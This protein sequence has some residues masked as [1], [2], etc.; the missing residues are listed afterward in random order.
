VFCHVIR[1]FEPEI[2]KVR[3]KEPVAVVQSV[4]PFQA[5]HTV[6]HSY[7]IP[8]MSKREL[9]LSNGAVDIDPIR[10]KRRKEDEDVPMSSPPTGAENV[11]SGGG[12]GKSS[13]E[14]ASLKEQGLELW[15]SIKNA[16]NKECVRGHA[17]PFSHSSLRCSS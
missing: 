1:R 7:S 14:G 13:M 5:Q 16:V 4:F 17:T 11:A 2:D 9:R 15:T 3:Q 12:G 8:K 6:I 10:L